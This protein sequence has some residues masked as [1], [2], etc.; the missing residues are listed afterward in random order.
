MRH[1]VLLFTSVII[2]L[3]LMTLEIRGC[4]FECV[5]DYSTPIHPIAHVNYPRIIATQLST[6]LN[7]RWRM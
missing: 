2:S 6:A 5:H 1:N 3:Y 7:R 4:V